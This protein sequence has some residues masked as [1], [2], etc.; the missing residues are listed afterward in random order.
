MARSGNNV[1]VHVLV[2]MVVLWDGAAAGAAALP[3]PDLETTTTMN[4]TVTGSLSAD[5]HLESCPDLHSMV[6]SAVQAARNQDVQITAGLLRI[7]F[8]DCFPQV[9]IDPPCYVKTLLMLTMT[10]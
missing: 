7:F 9:T 3:L 8:H 4:D 2:A 10:N 5:F 1:V 6:R